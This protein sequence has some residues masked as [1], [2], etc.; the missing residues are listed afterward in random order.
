MPRVS[1]PRVSDP[2]V[3]RALD[4]IVRH[5]EA[6]YGATNVYKKGTAS[7]HADGKLGDLRVVNKGA[8]QFAMEAKTEDGWRE[9]GGEAAEAEPGGGGEANT[10]SN[11]GTGNGIFK[12]K[13]GVDL[14]FKSLKA[15]GAI[16][17]TPSVNEIEISAP[18]GAGEANTASNVGAAG[19]G[20]FKQKTA[21]DL[22][23]KKIKGAGAIGVAAAGVSEI[24]ITTTAE[25]NTASN[26]GTGAGV[27]KS[28]VASDLVFRTILAGEGVFVDALTDEVE[29]SSTNPLTF[30]NLG[31]GEGEV[32]KET[33]ADPNLSFTNLG[34]GEGEIF[35]EI[36]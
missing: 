4:D 14:A 34:D 2:A 1:T 12:G 15:A 16:T 28:K 17:L 29:I 6:L 13:T 30:V 32:W 18:A 7:E 31:A 20:I 27:F 23:F 21:V 8:K 35:K 5:L 36:V 33:I 24:E 25:L 9:M 10:A 22:E 26:V 11:A 3:Q 19:E